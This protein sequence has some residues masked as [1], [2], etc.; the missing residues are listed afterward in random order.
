MS[1]QML[2]ASFRVAGYHQDQKAFVRLYTE[3]RIDLG[4]AKKNMELDSSKNLQALNVDVAEMKNWAINFNYPGKNLDI[5]KR[6]QRHEEL[7]VQI[8]SGLISQG[9]EKQA[10]DEWVEQAYLIYRTM[11]DKIR[12][13]EMKGQL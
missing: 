8:I 12:E 3:N 4:K 7:M 2:L 6:C 9:H 1:R 5:L 11:R 13:C 10:P